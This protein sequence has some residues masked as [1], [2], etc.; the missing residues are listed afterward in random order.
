LRFATRSSAFIASGYQFSIN[1]SNTYY[2]RT[3]ENHQKDYFLKPYEDNEKG[4]IQK[5]PIKVAL[6]VLSTRHYIFSRIVL[7][8]KL[9]QKKS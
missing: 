1:I 5:K 8:D 6:I 7:L 3:D 2:L 4:R 9:I